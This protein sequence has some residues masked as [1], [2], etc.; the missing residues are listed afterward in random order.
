[1]NTASNS[2]PFA[3]CRVISVTAPRLS[4]FVSS[5]SVESDTVSRNP[6]REASGAPASYSATDAMNSSRFSSLA[7]TFS[8]GPFSR[9]SAYPVSSMIVSISSDG[10]A[11]RERAMNRAMSALNASSFFFTRASSP[12]E[13]RSI[14]TSIT[15]SPRRAASAASFCNVASPIPRRGVLMT[16]IRLTSSRGCP[17]PEDRQ[18][19][20]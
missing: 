18:R 13:S 8:P 7:C 4:F 16:R 12:D 19:G 10:R 15:D 3:L 6:L 14:S 5:M 9:C 17:A 1:M 11:T 20:P 2:R